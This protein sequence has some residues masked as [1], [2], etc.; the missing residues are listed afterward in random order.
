M[1]F[2][3]QV[4]TKIIKDFCCHGNIVGIATNYL[5]GLSCP[6]ES[7]CTAKEQRYEIICCCHGN[8]VTITSNY[9]ASLFSSNDPSCNCK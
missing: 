2:D 5:A 1:K 8:I 3:P 7:S 4:N 9:F 6:I